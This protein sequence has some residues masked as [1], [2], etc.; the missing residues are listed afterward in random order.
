[1][2]AW[3]SFSPYASCFLSP[4]FSLLAFAPRIREW[5]C[6]VSTARP[7]VCAGVCARACV[8]LRARACVCAG[9]RACVFARLCA[10]A[11]VRVSVRAR[12]FVFV[13]VCV[14]VRARGWSGCAQ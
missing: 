10:R 6:D 1:V 7:C 4:S 3:T 12:A 13:R 14:L 2:A 5:M 9:V 11:W 8:C